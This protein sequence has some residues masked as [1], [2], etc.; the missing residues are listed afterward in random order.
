[1]TPETDRQIVAYTMGE[2]ADQ[3]VT[4]E[5]F[6]PKADMQYCNPNAHRKL[7]KTT[8]EPDIPEFRTSLKETR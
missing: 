5:P 7:L 3:A 4:F 1:M 8:V 6:E 2:L